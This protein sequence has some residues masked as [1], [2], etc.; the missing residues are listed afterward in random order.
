[1]VLPA[2]RS[3]DRRRRFAPPHHEG[4]I[5]AQPVRPHPEGRA[6][7]RVSKDGPRKDWRGT[8]SLAGTVAATLAPGSSLEKA[9]SYDIL[10]SAGL[11][12][13]TFGGVSAM[14]NLVTGLS[15]TPTD[16]FL[17]VTAAQLGHSSG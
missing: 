11:G 7:A 14:P 6:L 16:V 3:I 13:S 2:M 15:Y 17:N 8:A 1:M 5:P 9:S 12:G 4:L 10:H